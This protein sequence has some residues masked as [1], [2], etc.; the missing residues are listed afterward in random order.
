M[1]IFFLYHKK[2]KESHA[3]PILRVANQI[4]IKCIPCPSNPGSPEFLWPDYDDSNRRMEL[5][6][7]FKETERQNPDLVIV[8]TRSLTPYL[9]KTQIPLILLEHTDGTALELSR[10]LIDLDNILS[11]VKGSVFTDYNFYNSHTCEGMFHGNFIND[12][13]LKKNKPYKKISKNNFKKILLGYSFGCFPKNKRFLNY[14]LKKNR[15]IDISFVGNLKYSRSKLVTHHRKKAAT[16][17]STIEKSLFCQNLSLSEYDDVL[18]NSKICLSPYG[19]GVCYRSFESIF[20]G[21]LTV[22]PY[23][24]FMKTW[25]NIFIKNKIY[26][27]CKSNFLDLKN[28]CEFLLDNYENLIKDIYQKRQELIDCFFNDDILSKHIYDN[29]ILKSIEKH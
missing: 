16:C 20:S 23:S 19:Y 13:N 7:I 14:N 5:D 18:L 26:F 29:I 10:H 28:I 12:L 11:V 25:P 24:D 21:C 3:E 15:D 9:L 27:E 6:E 22:Q 4:G 1:K 2:W 17:L 8:H